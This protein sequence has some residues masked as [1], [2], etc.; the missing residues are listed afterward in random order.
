M[1]RKTI[2]FSLLA[3]LMLNV[4]A[5]CSS[6]DDDDTN[7]T[8]DNNGRRPRLLTITEAEGETRATLTTE[9]NELAAQWT[10]SDN[11]TCCNL[12]YSEM[13]S[14]AQTSNMTAVST[15]KTTQFTGTVDCVTGDRLAIVY[16]A[17]TFTGSTSFKYTIGLSDQDGT[18]AT[19]ATSYHYVYGVAKVE[20]VT[21]GT[22]N[23]T[24]AKMKS[25][26]TV[27]KFSFVDKADNS[28]ITISRLDIS[29]DNDGDGGNSGTYPQSATVTAAADPT[30]VKAT[31]VAGSGP[32]TVTP[33]APAQE[34]YVA[35]LPVGTNEAKRTFRF[36]VTDSNGATY[37]GTARAALY[38]GGYL[39]ATGLMLT[40]N[41]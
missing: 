3:L 40:K 36:T 17:T 21:D 23:A 29:Y 12:D 6:S 20:S 8:A 18:L 16:P 27:C 37:T 19:L 26:L 34:V 2:F 1:N 14:S 11:I 24:M 32:L 41:Q 39:A 5:G 22:A 15:A 9:N 38:E 30:A 31:A 33:A 4:S 25:L 7:T 35:L 10:A 28:P 13:V